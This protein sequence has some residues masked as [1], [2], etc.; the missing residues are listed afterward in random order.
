MP[1]ME[2]PRVLIADDEAHIRLLLKTLLRSIN[3]EVV[4]EAKNGLEA[5]ELYRNLKPD[6]VLMDINMP[7]MT[8]EAALRQ[9]RTEYPTSRIIMLTSLADMQIIARCVKL[10][11]AYYIRK[12]TPTGEIKAM[13]QKIMQSSFGPLEGRS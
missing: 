2:K 1:E 3:Y 4:G 5:V 9:I 12:D 6:M 11:A 10:G 7:I 8:G 13:L